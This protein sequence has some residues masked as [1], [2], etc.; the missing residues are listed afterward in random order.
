M[1]RSLKCFLISLIIIYRGCEISFWLHHCFNNKTS[2]KAKV[3]KWIYIRFLKNIIFNVC[4]CSSNYSKPLKFLKVDLIRLKIYVKLLILTVWNFISLIIM[5]LVSA[6][7]L[8]F[9]ILSKNVNVL[10]STL[11]DDLILK[12]RR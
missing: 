6:F 11:L 1:K 3:Y 12:N 4:C 8:M 5:L 9:T 2:I 10:M 7:S